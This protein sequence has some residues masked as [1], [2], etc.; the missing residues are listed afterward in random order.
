MPLWQNAWMISFGNEET[1]IIFIR[2][3]K[4]T[5][6]KR[7]KKKIYK[8]G[9]NIKYMYKKEKYNTV[10]YNYSYIRRYECNILE[11]ILKEVT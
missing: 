9:K 7:K 2:I 3:S 10:T 4:Y 5:Q 8:T 6:C 11:D 1:I